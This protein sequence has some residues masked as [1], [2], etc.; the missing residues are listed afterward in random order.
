MNARTKI[1]ACEY[2]APPSEEVA[3][4]LHW[5]AI[6]VPA[7]KEAA[8]CMLLSRAGYTVFIP[9]GVKLRRKNRYCAQRRAMRYPLLIRYVLI[10][11]AEAVPVWLSLFRFHIVQSVVCVGGVPAEIP[12]PAMERLFRLH[13]SDGEPTATAA[14]RAMKTHHEFAVGDVVEVVDGAFTGRDV[15]VS[16]LGG[17]KAKVLLSLFGRET[18]I[19]TE[20]DKLMPYD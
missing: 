18:E 19:E 20:I 14:Q 12:Y 5:Y 3:R 11:F 17:I 15:V 2:T 6:R 13:S 4:G 7:K 9:F 10:G 8:A 16:E 1:D